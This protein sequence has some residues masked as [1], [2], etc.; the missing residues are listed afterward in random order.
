[1]TFLQCAA[2]SLP[3]FRSSPHKLLSK[4]AI[5]SIPWQSAHYQPVKIRDCTFPFKQDGLSRR[6]RRLLT[7]KWNNTKQTR[8]CCSPIFLF[9]SRCLN[10]IPSSP[11]SLA[12]SYYFQ[13]GA[14]VF[15]QSFVE[16]FFSGGGDATHKWKQIC[17]LRHVQSYLRRQ[18]QRLAKH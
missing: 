13:F 3:P 2:G 5:T 7:L 4:L 14:S 17:V 18:R 11:C 9:P 16:S 12:R 8:S 15:C 6:P 10:S 1:M